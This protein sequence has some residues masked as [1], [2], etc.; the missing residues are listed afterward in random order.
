MTKF[1]LCGSVLGNEE[2][3]RREWGY[4]TFKPN[5]QKTWLYIIMVFYQTTFYPP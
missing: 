2:R 1:S 3:M 5:E 4:M